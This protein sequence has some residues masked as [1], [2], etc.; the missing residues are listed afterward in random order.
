MIWARRQGF[1]YILLDCDADQV[2]E[3]PVFGW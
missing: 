2:E 1:A 3:L